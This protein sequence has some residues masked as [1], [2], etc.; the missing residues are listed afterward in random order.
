MTTKPDDVTDAVWAEARR[1]FDDAADSETGNPHW[2]QMR[3]EDIARVIQ[4][5]EK[6]GEERERKACAE[7]KAERDLL[8]DILDSRPAINASL[9]DSYIQWSQAI[10]SG[11]VVRAAIRNRQ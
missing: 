1:W 3:Q 2:C 6:R 8:Q 10:Y 9:P 4:S 5:A 11:D 7:I